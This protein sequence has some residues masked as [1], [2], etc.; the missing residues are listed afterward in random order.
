[1]I[2][3]PPK[4]TLYDWLDYLDQLHP[5]EID[6]GLER[7]AQVRDA[8]G[9]NPEFLI[10]TVG[11]TNG[12]GSV[13]AMLE[14]IVHCAGYQVGC[15][16]SPHLLRYNERI[17]ID[18]HEVTDE[19][20]CK[21]FSLVESARVEANVTLTYFEFGTLAAM[22]LFIQAKIDVAVLEVGLGGR[23]D[24]VNVFDAD[25][26]VLTSIG[27]DHMDYLGSTREAIGREK[28]GIFRSKR[29]AICGESDIPE[30]LYPLMAATGANLC[31]FGKD[32]YYSAD[33]RQWRY[34]GIQGRT[35]NLPLPALRGEFQ[36]QNASVAFAAIEALQDRLP[37]SM[38][39]IRQGLVEITLPGRFQIVS[40]H[41][42]V[43]LDVAHNPAAARKL[44]TNLAKMPMR[45]RSFAVI[46]MLKDKDIVG[47][48]QELKNNIDYWLVAALSTARGASCTEI[49]DALKQAEVAEDRII[50]TFSNVPEAYA[51]AR[52]RVSDSD[53]IC[54]FGSFY[55]IGPVLEMHK[56]SIL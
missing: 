54:V 18:Q 27:L 48:V 16:T 22:L 32:F 46:A 28:I 15:Y 41:P 6:M 7:V 35:H 56:I 30:H 11:G 23:L 33:A 50:G 9:L 24:A 29:P 43:I 4:K 44:A 12:K 49:L 19:A 37:V 1:M 51:S 25:C 3:T 8:L 52:E 42:A 20:L 31:Y 36:L 40:A 47:T 26:A 17:H 55:T 53:R 38:N 21:A 10:I 2:D 5:K 13:C 34:T 45:G 14:S 39:A